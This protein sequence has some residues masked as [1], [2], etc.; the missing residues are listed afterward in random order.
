MHRFHKC[1]LVI[2]FHTFCVALVIITAVAVVS[3][4]AKIVFI[5]ELLSIS[6][7]CKLEDLKLTNRGRHLR[8]HQYLKEADMI[9]DVCSSYF[10]MVEKLKLR[11]RL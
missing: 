9:R 2:L 7:I 6:L 10:L 11:P 5:I 3:N 4:Y 1:N 8:T